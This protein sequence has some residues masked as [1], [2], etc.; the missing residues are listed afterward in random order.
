MMKEDIKI[1]NK[2][3]GEYGSKEII[4]GLIEVLTQQADEMSDLGLKENSAQT[5]NMADVLRDIIGE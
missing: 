4:R 2:L 1:L 5:A 3:V